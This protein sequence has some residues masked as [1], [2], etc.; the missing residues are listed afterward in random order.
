MIV[1]S[2]LDPQ[3]LLS[4]GWERFLTLPRPATAQAHNTHFKMCLSVMLFY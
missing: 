1:G 4:S 3:G 2:P